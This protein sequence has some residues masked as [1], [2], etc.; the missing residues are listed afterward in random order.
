MKL[1]TGFR[2][3]RYK[4]GEFL[5]SGS[6]A[7]VYTCIPL[8]S[9]DTALPPQARYVAK[10]FKLPSD[11][12]QYDRRKRLFLKELETLERLDANIHI[13]RILE[14]GTFL[15]NESDKE[16]PYCVLPRLTG[17]T[18]TSRI[19]D[20]PLS[21]TE[22]LKIGIGLADALH[23]AHQNGI[24]H[25]DVKPDNVMLDESGNPVWI[26]F[27]VAKAYNPSEEG[28]SV[29]SEA[30]TVAV[31]TAP[32]MSPE[33]FRGRH[34]LC[35]ASDI[36]SM[37][38]LLT[39][40]LTKKFPFGKEFEQVRQNI[41]NQTWTDFADL[42]SDYPQ[43]LDDIPEALQAVLNQCLRV[44]LNERYTSVLAFKKDL[45]SILSGGNSITTTPAPAVAIPANETSNRTRPFWFAVALLALM[46][47]GVWAWQTFFEEAEKPLILQSPTDNPTQ[48][49]PKS[50]STQIL[51]NPQNPQNQPSVQPLPNTPQQ[52]PTT[53][54]NPNPNPTNPSTTQPPQQNNPRPETPAPNTSNPTAAA[55]IWVQFVPQSGYN[56][57][58]TRINGETINPN[59]GL[60]QPFESKM[61]QTLTWEIETLSQEIIRHSIRIPQNLSPNQTIRINWESGA[62]E[63]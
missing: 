13:V 38:V 49:K 44:S 46:S 60:M 9:P 41:K 31:G 10:V 35:P 21:A 50:D 45:E 27:G 5:T 42:M 22:V 19:K 30:G 48:T 39:R 32:Y 62:I 37:G 8:N 63:P 26:D 23:Y 4:I 61:G 7:D 47:G 3:D 36:W 34:A 6:T 54:S 55:S 51:V 43:Y 1:A 52:I 25:C 14:K 15:D 20:F 33:H 53:T 11:L 58:K 59:L 12:Q 40:L 57:Q 24:L 2:L 17:G 29:M 18:L 56:P 28:A 16:I